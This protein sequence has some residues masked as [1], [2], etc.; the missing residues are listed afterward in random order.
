[1]LGMNTI[2]LILL[3]SVMCSESKKR[4]LRHTTYSRSLNNVKQNNAVTTAAA[5]QGT[6]ST[7]TK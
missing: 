5:I 1:M 4:S 3:N 7:V 2:Y 6:I